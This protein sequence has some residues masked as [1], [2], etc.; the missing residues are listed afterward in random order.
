MP[1]PFKFKNDPNAELPIDQPRQ[2]GACGKLH[3]P[4]GID[5]QYWHQG[6]PFDPACMMPAPR[7]YD[8]EAFAQRE[9]R[10]ERAAMLIY[11]AAPGVQNSAEH[12]Y[13][14]ALICGM[15]SKWHWDHEHESIKEIHRFAALQAFEAFEG[16][17]DIR[18]HEKGT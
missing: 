14:R 5:W 3:I 12:P 4:R 7:D 10:I 1:D 8:A 9:E 16:R 15:L 13:A 2:C 6:R 17:G 18:D 11:Y